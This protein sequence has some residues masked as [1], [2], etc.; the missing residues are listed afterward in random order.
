[1][2]RDKVQVFYYSKFWYLYIC[3]CLKPFMFGESIH[4]WLARKKKEQKEQNNNTTNKNKHQL[5]KPFFL[6]NLLNQTPKKGNN[7]ASLPPPFGD[8]PRRFW[9]RHSAEHLQRPTCRDPSQKLLRPSHRRVDNLAAPGQSV[10]LHCLRPSRRVPH[11]VRVPISPSFISK[12]VDARTNRLNLRRQ[13]S[14]REG[15]LSF[16]GRV[17][18]WI[19]FCFDYEIF[20]SAHLL[21]GWAV[22]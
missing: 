11:R 19:C 6:L 18:Y 7:I 20:S 15:D 4:C 9:S 1:M 17:L 12:V 21:N 14:P 3:F 8:F 2:V 10:D 5:L 13:P 16:F 22:N